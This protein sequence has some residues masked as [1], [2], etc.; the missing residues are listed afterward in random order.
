MRALCIAALAICAMDGFALT[1]SEKRG[2]SIYFGGTSASGRAITALVAGSVEL[3]A[4]SLPCGSC[5]GADGA[6]V[7]EG[8]I[9]P[10]DVRWPA[11]SQP[12]LGQKLRPRYDDALLRRAIVHGIDAADRPLS[13]VMPRYRMHDDDLADL[14]AWLRRL[15]DAEQ[16]G[17][18]SSTITIASAVQGPAADGTI[19]TLTAFAKDINDSGGIYGRTLRVEQA[20]DPERVF[21]I[22]CAT[23]IELDPYDR[24][25]VITPFPIEAPEASS[26]FLY[27]TLEIQARALATGLPEDRRL[28]IEHDDTTAARAAAAALG[29]PSPA[30]THLFLLGDVDLPAIL[31]RLEQ[32]NQTPHL[33]VAGSAVT[34]ELL[35]S[36][37][38]LSLAMPT[39]PSDMT[40]EGRREFEAFVARHDLPRTHLAT[41]IATYATMKVFLEALKRTGRD[42]T[43]EKLISSLERLYA[44]PTGLTPP[45]TFARNRHIGSSGAHVVSGDGAHRTF[46]TVGAQ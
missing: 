34:R 35:E 36:K 44:F 30:P 38:P 45:I 10:A 2:R 14:L 17:L 18:T 20:A 9:V 31:H 24:V 5:H 23:E 7:A 28:A 19:A 22:V 8:T 27:P 42:L 29:T 33:L 15:G 11:L 21:A 43:R 26:F 6:G 39:L 3:P 13:T 4:S 12:R 40:A 25:P 37:R 1:E 41:Q 46:V 32:A 16:P